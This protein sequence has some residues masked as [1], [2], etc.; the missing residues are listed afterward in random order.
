[1]PM[2]KLRPLLLA[3]IAL[4]WA[5]LASAINYSSTDLLLVFRQDGQ[6]DVEFD[7]GSVTNFL[8]KTPG[9]RI[10]VAY[11]LSTVLGNFGGSLA[12]VKFVVVGTTTQSDLQPR[13]WLTDGNVATPPAEPTGS[14][15]GVLHDKVDSVGVNATYATLSNSAPYAVATSAG[16]AYDYLVTSG[17]GTAVSTMYGDAPSPV[18]SVVPLPVDALNPTTLAFYEL[19]IATVTPAPAASL[20][21]A[22]TLDVAGNL[23]FTAGQL[24]PLAS[25]TIT[26][27][28]ADPEVSGTSS[29]S[30]T[31]TNGVN[32]RL[33]YSTALGGPWTRVPGTL[34]ANG[35]GTVQSLTNNYATDPIQFYRIQSTY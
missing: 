34:P 32:Y 7:L 15:F 11:N 23:Y 5:Q 6:R 29:V 4:P 12:G 22:F 20:I 13:L 21:G 24:P 8:G 1:M 35:D 2:K 33:L 25:S 28:S 3:A 18:G 9:T 10:T 26:A 17:A 31:T 19:H 14:A 30:F 27:I 16:S